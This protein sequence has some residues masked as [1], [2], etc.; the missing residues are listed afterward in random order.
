MVP[1]NPSVRQQ[2]VEM[3]VVKC[4]I[5]LGRIAVEPGD[6]C[7]A[8]ISPAIRSRTYVRPL[9]AWINIGLLSTQRGMS[10]TAGASSSVPPRPSLVKSPGYGV[11]PWGEERRPTWTK[12]RS[13]ARPPGLFIWPVIAPSASGLGMPPN[14]PFPPSDDSETGSPAQSRGEMPRSCIVC[15]SSI[16]SSSHTASRVCLTLFWAARGGKF[17]VCPSADD[18][19]ATR[20]ARHILR[21]F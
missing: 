4:P 11:L 10:K 17:R 21:G 7:R 14:C 18:C 16:A 20:R 19:A 8:R 1:G 3:A 15:E 2:R 13:R 5:G 9:G 6:Q 12:A